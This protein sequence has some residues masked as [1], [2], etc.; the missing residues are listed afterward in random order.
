M[1]RGEESSSREVWGRGKGRGLRAL[2][3]VWQCAWG[4]GAQCGRKA[5][6][7]AGAERCVEW[8]LRAE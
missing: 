3:V 8:A 2:G 7:R 4:K 1:K 6:F 5:V